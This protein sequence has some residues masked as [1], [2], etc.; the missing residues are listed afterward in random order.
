MCVC[1]AVDTNRGTKTI[2]FTALL[3]LSSFIYVA[4]YVTSNEIIYNGLRMSKGRK[5]A[6]KVERDAVKCSTA[7]CLSSLTFSSFKVMPTPEARLLD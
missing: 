3:S 5:T 4:N 6:G 1:V 2:L 7:Y